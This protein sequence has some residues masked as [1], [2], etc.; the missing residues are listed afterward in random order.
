MIRKRTTRELDFYELDEEVGTIDCGTSRPT[1]DIAL[2]ALAFQQHGVFRYSGSILTVWYKGGLREP[3]PFGCS[4][5]YWRW[6]AQQMKPYLPDK[7]TGTALW[8]M[9]NGELSGKPQC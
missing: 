3:Q 9:N 8:N 1:I 4:K 5:E 7:Y 6:I 2:Q